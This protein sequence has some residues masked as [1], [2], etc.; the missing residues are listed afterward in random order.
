M[1]PVLVKAHKALDAAVDKCYRK[2]PFKSE[3]DRVEYLFTLYEKYTEGQTLGL[4]TTSKKAKGKS[5]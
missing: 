3:L 1:P 4:E 2:E 5:K